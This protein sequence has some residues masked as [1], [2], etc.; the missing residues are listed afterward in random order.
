FEGQVA[1]EPDRL[2]AGRGGC[3]A[4]YAECAERKEDE[5]QGRANGAYVRWARGGSVGHRRQGS[6]RFLMER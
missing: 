6:G 3:G 1:A 5:D 4:Q 2:D